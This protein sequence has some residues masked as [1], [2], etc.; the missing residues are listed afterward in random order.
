L[1]QISERV[2]ETTRTAFTSSRLEGG[3]EEVTPHLLLRSLL[4]GLFVA[5]SPSPALRVATTDAGGLLQLTQT[6]GTK[7]SEF[8]IGH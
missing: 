8:G 2:K 1:R 3:R 5:P 6:C 4:F 7:G